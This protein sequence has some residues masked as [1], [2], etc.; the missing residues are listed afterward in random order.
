MGAASRNRSERCSISADG[1]YVMF[2]SQA[3]NLVP[4]DTNLV[5][6]SGPD[7]ASRID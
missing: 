1:R 7:T 3:D 5:I 2:D 4:G 6:Q